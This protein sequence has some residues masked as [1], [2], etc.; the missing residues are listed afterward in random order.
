M[1]AGVCFLG[2]IFYK[3]VH[4]WKIFTNFYVLL[5]FRNFVFVKIVE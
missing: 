3:F 1:A 2:V 4:F 5:V